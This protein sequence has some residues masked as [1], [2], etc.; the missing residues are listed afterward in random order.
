MSVPL[1]EVIGC[2]RNGSWRAIREGNGLLEEYLCETCYQ[3][4]ESWYP[5]RATCYAPR[6]VV[7]AEEFSDRKSTNR[8]TGIAP[9]DHRANLCFRQRSSQ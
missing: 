1:C 6:N 7:D 4:L 2:H 5:E 9:V 3:I 8:E